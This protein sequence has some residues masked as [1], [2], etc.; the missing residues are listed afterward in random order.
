MRS[1]SKRV[2]SLQNPPLT[3]RNLTLSEVSESEGGVRKAPEDAGGCKKEK[4]A[5]GSRLLRQSLVSK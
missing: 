4:D 2:I 1:P 3:F 5:G